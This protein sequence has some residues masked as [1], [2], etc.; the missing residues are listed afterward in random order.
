MK[1]T[2][3][4]RTAL[5]R[6]VEIFLGGS[7]TKRTDDGTG[8]KSSYVTA[9][10]FKGTIESIT[11]DGEVTVL[12]LYWEWDSDTRKNIGRKKRAYLH[13]DC[14]AAITIY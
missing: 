10:S 7:D 8:S 13:I 12:Q 1:I 6:E 3:R 2:E 11:E 14:I 4:V 9:Q 5:N